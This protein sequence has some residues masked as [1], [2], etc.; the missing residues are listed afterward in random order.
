[1]ILQ[2]SITAE[3]CKAVQ[4]Y[5]QADYTRF[6]TDFLGMNP[7]HIWSGMRQIADSVRDHQK[8]CVYS[9]HSL[10]KDYGCSRL[11]LAFLYAHGPKC[12][13]VVTGPGNNQ[14]ENIFCR[15][16]RDAFNSAIQ[17]L[18]GKLTTTKLELDDKWFLLGFTTDKDDTG[19]A[20]RFQGFHNEN[21]LVIF[22][23]AAGVPHHIWSATEHLIVNKGHRWLVY[24]NATSAT[25]DFANCIKD[26]TW[27]IINLSVLNSPNYLADEEVIPGISGRMYE[28][29]IRNKYGADSDEYRVRVLGLISNK[30]T[31]GSY[32]AEKI[33]DMRKTGRICTVSPDNDTLINVVIDPGYTTSM[34]LFQPDGTDNR[35]I[36]AYK[37][38]GLGID[39]YGRL[40]REWEKEYGYKYDKVFVPCDMNNNAHRVTRGETALEILKSMGFNVESLPRE[41]NVVREGIPRTLHFL[42]RCWI[43]KD[44]CKSF[45]V[46]IEN[47]HERVNKRMSDD[48]NVVYTGSPEKD[49]NDH[50]ADMLRYMSLAYKLDKVRTN[51]TTG[52]NR[53]EIDR[54]ARLYR[55]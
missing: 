40:L 9:G 44:N 5:L 11:A 27:N 48:E 19:E 26:E 54:L 39:G 53:D 10:S 28:Q 2:E 20:T 41:I 51:K 55:R 43:S 18:Q 37:D 12:T 47:Y 22:T 21:V 14:V 1:M 16:I 34:G 52:M 38:S 33:A 49:G 8:T 50:D 25:G 4:Q 32:Y 36:R 45:I 30:G 42:D 15:E 7:E 31:V 13:V 46:C 24:G 3:D 35:I 17:P 29:K 23:E 6:Y